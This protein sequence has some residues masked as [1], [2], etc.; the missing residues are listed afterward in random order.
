MTER[1]LILVKP[2]GVA[3][4]LVGAVLGRLVRR[5]GFAWH[6]WAAQP[7]VALL[8]LNKDPVLLWT[9]P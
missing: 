5:A 4:G 6:R 1:T 7:S 2:D 3:R 8:Q 9:G